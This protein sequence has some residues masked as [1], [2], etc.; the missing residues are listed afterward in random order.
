[1]RKIIINQAE[2]YVDI[3]INTAK[4]T[5][6]SFF[7]VTIIYQYINYFNIFFLF[8]SLILSIKIIFPMEP[9]VVIGPF[10]FVILV[11]VVREAIEDIVRKY[12]NL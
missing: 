8:A 5:L 9:G 4:N 12:F 3:K 2:S 1:M 7:P 11:S 6:L 10:I